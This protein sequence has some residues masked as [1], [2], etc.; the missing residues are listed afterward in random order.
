MPEELIHEM[1]EAD[2]DHTALEL[3]AMEETAAELTKMGAAAHYGAASGAAGEVDAPPKGEYEGEIVVQAKGE[4]A[5]GPAA[6]GDD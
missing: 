6:E 5:E 2:P 1:L 4:H 3:K